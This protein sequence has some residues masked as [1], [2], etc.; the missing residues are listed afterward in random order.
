MS[1]VHWSRRLA[2]YLCCSPCRTTGRRAG[3][4][5]CHHAW[6]FPSR[7]GHGHGGG[8]LTAE[9]VAAFTIRLVTSHRS[10]LFPV[11]LSDTGQTTDRQPVHHHTPSTSAMT[12]S[13][14]IV[15]VNAMRMRR[16]LCRRGWRY[17]RGFQPYRKRLGPI[18]AALHSVVFGVLASS[19]AAVSKAKPRMST[20]VTA[21]NFPAAST[22]LSGPVR[23]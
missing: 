7:I 20:S 5:A 8:K 19:P 22:R 15:G 18:S 16:R 14:N 21:Q 4:R 10:S 3:L 23:A 12:G 13:G 17:L 11:A 2:K 6:R 9:R 1:Q